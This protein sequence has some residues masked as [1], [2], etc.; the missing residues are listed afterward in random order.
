MQSEAGHPWK[1]NLLVC[2]TG[3]HQLVCIKR[4]LDSVFSSLDEVKLSDV[5]YFHK[6]LAATVDGAAVKNGKCCG[7]LAQLQSDQ[8]CLAHISELAIK[9][10]EFK[11]VSMYSYCNQPGKFVRWL[12]AT[13][14]AVLS[15]SLLVS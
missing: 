2:W 7:V 11:E 3:E 5:D 14:E 9:H 15:T 10:H 4:S 12:N 13:M 6:L 1:S 8:P